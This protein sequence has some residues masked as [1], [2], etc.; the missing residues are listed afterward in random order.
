M[1]K[2]KITYTDF[3]DVEH[4]EDFYFNLSKTEL[5]EMEMS[6]D[7]GMAHM[8]QQIVESENTKEMFSLFKKIIL[9]SVGTKSEDGKRFFKSD[10]IAQDFVASP[11]FDVLF[12]S[13]ATDADSAAEFIKGI[14]PQDLVGSFDAAAKA[15]N[16][17]AVETPKQ[18]DPS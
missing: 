1:L 16:L 15:T 10:E 5:T 14:I 9:A 3:N 11:A 13:L 12:M 2:K 7:S 17:A 4:S 6:V 8:L 18:T